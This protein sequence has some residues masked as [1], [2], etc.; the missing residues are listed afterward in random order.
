MFE[1][2]LDR[3]ERTLEALAGARK[4]LRSTIPPEDDRISEGKSRWPSRTRTLKV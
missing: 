4:D 3:N 2:V 1:D